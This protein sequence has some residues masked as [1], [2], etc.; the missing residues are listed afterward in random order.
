MWLLRAADGY[1]SFEMTWSVCGSPDCGGWYTW[2]NWLC[3]R[4]LVT[5]YAL[6]N[7]EYMPYTLI[8]LRQKYS[9]EEAIGRTMSW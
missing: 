1:S 7:K 9:D 6:P 8:S 2:K 4:Q 3:E 5:I